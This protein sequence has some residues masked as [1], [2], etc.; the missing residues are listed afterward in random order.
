MKD[1]SGNWLPL[2]GPHYDDA[3]DALFEENRQRLGL[4]EVPVEASAGDVVLFHGVLIHRGGPIGRP[5]S[6]RHV[7][8]NHYIPRGFDAWPYPD[9]PR[10]DFDGNRRF[11]KAQVA[12][13][14][15]GVEAAPA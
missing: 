1:E 8:A 2:F 4:R 13:L 6:F 12:G 14:P 10:Y 15:H 7:M 9:W 11:T 5:G 3:V